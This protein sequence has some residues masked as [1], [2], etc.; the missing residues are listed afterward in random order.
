MAEYFI[1]SNLK[2]FI[3][4]GYSGVRVHFCNPRTQDVETRKAR[5]QSQIQLH[6]K[7]KTSPGYVGP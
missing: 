4:K 2:F 6:I 5:V 3:S 7:F 1:V